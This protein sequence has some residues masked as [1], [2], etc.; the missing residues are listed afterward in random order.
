MLEG[1]LRRLADMQVMK[2]L[3][4]DDLVKLRPD[5][6]DLIVGPPIVGPVIVGGAGTPAPI[7]TTL[8]PVP[9]DVRPGDLI[10]A[11]DWN[12]VLAR[13]RALDGVLAALAQGTAQL[14]GRVNDLARRVPAAPGGEVGLRPERD[15]LLDFLGSRAVREAI[16]ND[17]TLLK[18]IA[19]SSR[20][21]EAVAADVDLVR[22][23]VLGTAVGPVS[24]G[25]P[26]EPVMTEAETTA[27]KER[28]E[29]SPLF[30]GMLKNEAIAEGLG[31]KL[32]GGGG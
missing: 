15:S 5:I 6:G 22:G 4:V 17:E 9:A 23:A 13:L 14:T 20:V 28:M 21:T 25:E 32:P 3:T 29:A 18:A 16:A 31:L 30:S 11:E 1:T 24:G 12:A 19:K 27:L 2:Q 10:R 7:S 8:P 26:G